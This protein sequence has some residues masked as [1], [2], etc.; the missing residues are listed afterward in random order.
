MVV[1]KLTLLVEHCCHARSTLSPTDVPLCNMSQSQL[2]KVVDSIPHSIENIADIYPVTPLQN[3]ML[4]HTL[5]DHSEGMY[6]NQS[7]VDLKGALNVT[8]LELAWQ[9]VIDQ[10]A[11]LR[12]GFVWK[13]LDEPVQFVARE[14]SNDWQFIDWSEQAIGDAFRP[15]LD[16]QLA[17]LANDDL[18]Q[19]FDLTNAGLMRFKLVKMNNDHHSLVWTRHHLIVDGWCTSIILRDV[20]QAYSAICKHTQPALI[21]NRPYRDF[22]AWLN[23]RDTQKSEQYWAKCFAG[24]ENVA[25]LPKTMTQEASSPVARS[26]TQ[27]LDSLS[28]FDAEVLRNVAAKHRLTL[29]SL[30]QAI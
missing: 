25:R 30:C 24:Y 20:Q 29:N 12:S 18:K 1:E 26:Q 6:I 4:Y 2:D 14:I 15:N 19:G 17:Q 21:S 16:A 22:I 23:K 10:H 9:W 3:G 28:I 5:T 13:H 7:L 11:M 27:I 8:A